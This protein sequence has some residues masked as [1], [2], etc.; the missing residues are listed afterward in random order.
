MSEQKFPPKI[1]GSYDPESNNGRWQG[2]YQFCPEQWCI[3]YDKL[4]HTWAPTPGEMRDVVFIS[5]EEHQHILAENERR[6]EK[7]REALDGLLYYWTNTPCRFD[8]N[9]NCQAH[10]CFGYDRTCLVADARAALQEDGK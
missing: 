3:A 5:E 4:G 10:S 9:G 7:L 1:M 8:H 6:I 2:P